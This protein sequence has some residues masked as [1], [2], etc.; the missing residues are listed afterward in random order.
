MSKGTGWENLSSSAP[1]PEGTALGVRFNEEDKV[2]EII[3]IDFHVDRN[4][5]KISK[6]ISCGET[7]AHAIAK[8]NVRSFELK[9]N[10]P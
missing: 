6:V 7:K 5:A 4:Y 10:T 9:N 1:K 8:Y 3:E 2:W